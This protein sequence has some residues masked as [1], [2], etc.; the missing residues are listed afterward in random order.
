MALNTFIEYLE[1]E[2][3]YSQHTCQ[4]YQR[5]LSQFATFLESHVQQVLNDGEY[6]SIR[7]WIAVLSQEMSNRSINRKLSSLKAYYN[8]LQRVGLREDNPMASH[9]SLKTNMEFALP[10]SEQETELLLD[11]FRFADSYAGWR[12]RFLIELLYGTGMR[13]AELIGLT[14]G[15]LDL[16]KRIVL[17]RGKGNKERILPLLPDLTEVAKA[18]FRHLPKELPRG[19]DAPLFYTS[20]GKP[21]YPAFVYRTINKYLQEVS[22]K[23]KKSPHILRHT[24]ATHLLNRGADLNS[25]KE[26]L[27]HASLAST[28]VYTHSSIEELKKVHQAAHPR[29]KED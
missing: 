12:D 20:S 7:A 8:Y 2:K 29:S 16:S 13:R 4:A 11:E 18:Y 28:Q 26:L 10:L 23:V 9:R 17:V 24:F 14:Q 5:D 27:G 19:K 6:S 25:V 1:L 21:L 22:T 15:D 3:K